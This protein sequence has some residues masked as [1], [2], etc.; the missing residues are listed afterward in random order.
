LK[1]LI[2]P[3]LGNEV[4]LASQ[5]LQSAPALQRNNKDQIAALPLGA[6]VKLDP[7]SDRVTL[8]KTKAM[9]PNST[10]EKM[11][12][13]VTPL[14]PYLTRYVESAEAAADSNAAVALNQKN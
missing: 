7:Y 10:R 2:S 3:R 9:A 12:F 8:M 4:F 5:L 6:R 11:P 1:Q 14:V 13:E